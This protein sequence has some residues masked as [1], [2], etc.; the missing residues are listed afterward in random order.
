MGCK[1]THLISVLVITLFPKVF[2]L[3]A[4]GGQYEN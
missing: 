2:Q 1:T 3:E 4:Y